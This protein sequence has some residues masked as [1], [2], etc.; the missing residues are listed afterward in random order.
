MQGKIREQ[1][2][3]RSATMKRVS[4]QEEVEQ[5][6]H[7]LYQAGAYAEALELATCKAHIFPRHA[8]KVIFSWRMNCAIGLKDRELTL[9][10]LGEA[11]QAG[12]WYSNLQEDDDFALLHGDPEFEHLAGICNERRAQA[13]ANAVPVIK[14]FAPKHQSSPYPLLL[15]LHGANATAEAG[16]WKSA[17]SHG[18]FLGLPQSSQVFAPGTY[19][20]NDWDWAL[21]EVPQRFASICASHP[22][23]KDRVVLAGFSQG[24]GLAA[25]LGLGG[26]IPVRGLILV[27]PFLVN[28]NNLIPTLDKHG[29]YDLRA[30]IVAG[31]RDEYCHGVALQ[32][33]DLLP[34]YGI[35]CQLDVYAD[36]EHSFP[37]D[38][39]RKLPGALDYIMVG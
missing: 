14:T 16:H 6:F 23:D 20:W 8:Q 22:I 5:Q 29:P 15:A 12:Y 7:G 34:K 18:W 2:L 30:C 28:V 24:G 39:E 21:Q 1:H 19:T 17:I 9:H 4:R 10:L 37:L 26:A 25:W 3:K 11:I 27:G 33:A 38:F 31:A 13:M 32:L 36:M 35:Q